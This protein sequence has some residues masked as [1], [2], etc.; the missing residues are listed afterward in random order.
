MTANNGIEIERKFIVAEMPPPEFLNNPT[1]NHLGYLA[2]G[3]DGNEVR[4][5][6][7]RLLNTGEVYHNI[8]VKSKGGLVRDERETDLTKEQ[9]DVL[10]PMT[11]GKRL[12]KTRYRT[13]HDG[14]IYEID[15]YMGNL[16]GMMVLEIEFDNV[17]SASA[18]TPPSWVGNDVTEYG[19][20][21]NSNLA[22]LSAFPSNGIVMKDGE[23]IE[24]HK[25]Q[26]VGLH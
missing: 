5:R 8:T 26:P 21:K 18:Y 13:E 3:E 22:S 9:F 17:E 11:E 20:F 15:S 1:L 4:L 24:V 19:F 12:Y 25:L 10:W 2:V 16:V 23:I 7:A 6:N 14:L